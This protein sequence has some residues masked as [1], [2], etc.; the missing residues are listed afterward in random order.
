MTRTRDPR[1]ARLTLRDNVAVPIDSHFESRTLMR[2]R[3]TLAVAVPLFVLTATTALAMT[4]N[5]PPPPPPS[6]STTPTMP[7]GGSSGTSAEAGS[8]RQQAEQKYAL[9]YEEVGKANKDVE[10]GKGKNAEKKFRQ[11]LER[12]QDAVALD[13]R[14]HEAWN[15]IGYTSRK[16]NDYDNAF[17]A[18]EKCL[19]I[20]WDYAPAREYLGEAWL[21]K[22]DL[23]KAR[24]QLV[25]LA[26]IDARDESKVLEGKIAAYVAAHPGSDAAPA[27]TPAAAPAT[28]RSDTTAG[29]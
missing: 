6:T 5:P 18:Y 13:D 1:A 12:C 17:K 14:Y 24:E 20:K 21:E 29:H 9:A 10:D 11:A 4:G 7:S 28:A 26:K 23:A 8:A 25:M 15:L 3:N 19:S 2:F 27:S 22:G 16:L